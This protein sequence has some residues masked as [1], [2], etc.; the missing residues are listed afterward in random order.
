MKTLKLIGF[1]F[2]ASVLSGS[3]ADDLNLTPRYG[4]NADAVYSDPG[5]YI[6][7]LAKL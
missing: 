1:A 6:N 7:V 5:N 2:L 4:L 3:C